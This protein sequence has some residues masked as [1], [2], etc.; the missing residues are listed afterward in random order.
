MGT[1]PDW[2]EYR[3]LVNNMKRFGLVKQ[4]KMLSA[5]IRV[6]VSVERGDYAEAVHRLHT[7]AP[8]KLIRGDGNQ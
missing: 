4:A 7:E 2:N 6:A 3:K 5:L 1:G 8:Q